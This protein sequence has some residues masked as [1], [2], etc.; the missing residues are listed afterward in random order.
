M[1]KLV[2]ISIIIACLLAGFGVFYHYV[3][4][5][6]DVEQNKIERERAEKE[7]ADTR[8][9]VEKLLAAQREEAE[10]QEAERRK[11]ERQSAY[12]DCLGRAGKTYDANWANECKAQAKA[13]LVH[14]KNCLEDP[15]RGGNQFMGAKY[16]QS[17][18]GGADPSPTCSLPSG[19]AE[20]INKSHDKAKQQCLAEAKLF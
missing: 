16:C 20:N 2:K 19:V 5:L 14:L 12:Y 18:Y 3:I 8:A 7:V 11:L 9:K 1:D 4:F 15:N 6:P 17:T 10:K 13:R